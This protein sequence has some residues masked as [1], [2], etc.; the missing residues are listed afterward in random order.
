MLVEPAT[1]AGAAP[2]EGT[3]ES[4]EAMVVALQEECRM[5][6]SHVAAIDAGGALDDTSVAEAACLRLAEEEQILR[7]RLDAINAVR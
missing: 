1:G 6:E 4:V 7:Q 5:Y 2:S 3:L